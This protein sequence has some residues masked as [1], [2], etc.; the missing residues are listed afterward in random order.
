MIWCATTIKNVRALLHIMTWNQ[1]EI[2]K[3]GYYKVSHVRECD[4]RRKIMPSWNSEFLCSI[5]YGK[6]NRT[7]TEL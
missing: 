4:M 3:I 6:F 7:F 1:S 2:H 5:I